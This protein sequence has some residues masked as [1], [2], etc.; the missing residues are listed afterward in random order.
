MKKIGNGREPAEK[1]AKEPKEIHMNLWQQKDI[2]N[3]DDLNRWTFPEL[4]RDLHDSPVT[5]FELFMIDKLIDRICKETNTYAA[6]KT[7]HTFKIDLN[8]MKSF[9]AA[10]LLSGYIPYARCS[11]YLEM[12]LDS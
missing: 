4:V 9:L 3:T 6:Q 10:L 7:N 1:K 2:Q 12:W 8:E 11:M 5:L